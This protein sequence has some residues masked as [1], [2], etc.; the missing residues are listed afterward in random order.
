MKC[1]LSF[2]FGLCLML[3]FQNES[4]A[5]RSYRHFFEDGINRRIFKCRVELAGQPISGVLLVKRLSDFYFRAVYTAETGFTFFDIGMADD[6]S[7]FHAGVGPFKKKI[8]QRAMACVLQSVL[9]RPMQC[10]SET[11]QPS[12]WSCSQFRHVLSTEH[13]EEFPGRLDLY[14][15][16][17]MLSSAEF[18][19]THSRK[20]MPDSVYAAKNGFP[21]NMSFRLLNQ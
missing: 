14:K 5:K 6:V 21:L 20:Q 16:K 9:L 19:F 15:G 2:F 1:L 17:R 13:L 7:T 12:V 8:I 4:F 11:N 10:T 3:T 18:Y